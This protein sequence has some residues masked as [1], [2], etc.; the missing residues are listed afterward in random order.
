MNKISLNA[1]AT[2]IIAAIASGLTT[3]KEVAA[4]MG[5]GV[6][7]VTGNLASL[8]KNELISVEGG[9]MSLTKAGRK[10]APKQEKATKTTANPKSRK[11]RTG[12][13]A[14][15][16][17]GVFAARGK[18]DRKTIISELISVAGLSKNGAATYLQNLKRS[19]GLIK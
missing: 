17:R 10:Y 9:V 12:T 11:V 5:V 8:K 7:V 4:Q 1:N 18:K 2:A 13:K 19:A 15:L 14:E 3:S 6:P 16:A